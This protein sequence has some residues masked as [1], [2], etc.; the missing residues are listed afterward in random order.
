MLDAVEEQRLD[1]AAIR[2]LQVGVQHEQQ[3]QELILTDIKH[4]LSC[5]PL[6]PPY[7]QDLPTENLAGSGLLMWERFDEAIVPIGAPAWP[8]QTEAFAYDNESPRHRALVGAFALASRP[9]TCGEFREFIRD[10]GYA[11]PML[12]LSDGW[13]MAQAEGWKRPLY[14]MDEDREYTLGGVRVIDWQAPVCHLSYYEADA[15]ARWAGYRLPTE[16]EWETAA[17]TLNTDGNFAESGRLHP[18]AKEGEHLRQMFGDVWEWTSS[19]YL[20]YPGFRPMPGTLG[21]YNGKFM[22]GPWVLRGGSCASASDHLR[23]TYRNFF[24][25]LARWQFSGLRL[26]RD[27]CK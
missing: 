7:R 19:A 18:A 21:E 5:N 15:F 24:A 9:V 11:N 4:A 2:I 26:A 6:L 23:A 1:D 16:F 20:P 8:E 14:W 10:N 22:C 3:H 12:W 13:D 27:G 25:P 17:A